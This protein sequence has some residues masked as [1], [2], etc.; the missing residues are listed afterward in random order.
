VQ[1]Q[2]IS[3]RVSIKDEE[4]VK[5]GGDDHIMQSIYRIVLSRHEDPDIAL[6]GH[7]WEIVEFNKVGEMNQLI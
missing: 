2:E 3:C 5:K 4:E 1:I 7:Y 6:A